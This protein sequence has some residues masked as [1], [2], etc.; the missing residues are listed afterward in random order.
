MLF[1]IRAP[2]SLCFF[3]NLM[4]T[5][6]D[7]EGITVSQDNSSLF[8]GELSPRKVSSVA[9]L[10]G[11]EHFVR[12]LYTSDS[13]WTT[14]AWYPLL[15]CSSKTSSCKALESTRRNLWGSCLTCCYVCRAA[16][17]QPWGRAGQRR[18]HLSVL[19]IWYQAH[20]AASSGLQLMAV[21][22]LGTHKSTLHPLLACQRKSAC[23]FALHPLAFL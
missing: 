22:R 7:V 2:Q 11:P 16:Q 17:A 15:G 23:P 18:H 14:S 4:H 19:L 3:T 12:Q 13:H 9:K 6:K 1:F 5:S 8:S 20:R 21:H 10:L